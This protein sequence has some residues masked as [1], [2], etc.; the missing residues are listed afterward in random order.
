MQ[1]ASNIAQFA[2]ASLYGLYIG[3]ALSMPVHW[4]YNPEDIKT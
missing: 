4:F 1:Q 3:D 2:R